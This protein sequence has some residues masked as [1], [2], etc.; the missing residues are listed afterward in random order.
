[1]NDTDNEYRESQRR[2]RR[3]RTIRNIAVSAVLV[4]ILVGLFVIKFTR[5]NGIPDS[6]TVISE[7]TEEQ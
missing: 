1:M 6:A 2:K 3:A 4:L 7:T 5:E